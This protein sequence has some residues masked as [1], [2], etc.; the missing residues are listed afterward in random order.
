MCSV[1]RAAITGL[2]AI[3]LAPLAAAEARACDPACRCA[4]PPANLTA[5]NAARHAMACYSCSSTGST[6]A[7]QATT[8]RRQEAPGSACS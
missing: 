2:F 3:W 8:Q 1:R 6:R 5:R 7:S 4:E